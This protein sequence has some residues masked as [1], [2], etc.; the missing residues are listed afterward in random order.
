M[1]LVPESWFSHFL[2]LLSRRGDVVA[3]CGIGIL[4]LE[5][6]QKFLSDTQM[7]ETFSFLPRN[8]LSPIG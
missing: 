7:V 1:P 5:S 3:L 6:N 2:A 4:A 8:R